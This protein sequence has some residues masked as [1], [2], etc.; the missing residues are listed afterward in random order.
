MS[1]LA[2]VWR[3]ARRNADR[4]ADSATIA[5]FPTA[6]MTSLDADAT[7]AVG[8]T[9]ALNS[10][11]SDVTC[12]LPAAASCSSGDLIR[13][14]W[15]EACSPGDVIKIK[16]ADTE[17]FQAG[18]RVSFQSGPGPG[19][20]GRGNTS[21]DENNGLAANRVLTSTSATNGDGGAGSYVHCCFTGTAWS[22]VGHMAFQGAGTV[23]ASTSFGAS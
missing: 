4:E 18:S 5:D 13:V 12:T 7:L 6:A 10:K 22:L 15:S 23:D 1:T 14:I 16:P 11:G 21:V 20:A 9:Y 19:G 8:T 17:N 3:Y 2:E